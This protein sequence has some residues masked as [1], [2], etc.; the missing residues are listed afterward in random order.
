[1]RQLTAETRIRVKVP[2][3]L[4]RKRELTGETRIRLSQIVD[5]K[6]WRKYVKDEEDWDEAKHPRGQP[7]NSGQ[8]AKVF[9]K[10]LKEN[11]EDLQKTFD[12]A[13]VP[14]EEKEVIQEYTAGLSDKINAYR[15]DKTAPTNPALEEKIELLD[16]ALNRTTLEKNIRTYRTVTARK[17]KLEEILQVPGLGDVDEEDLG[18]FINAYLD[19]QNIKAHDEAFLSTTLDKNY[20]HKKRTSKQKKYLYL[21]KYTI[22]APKEA[23]GLYVESVTEYPGQNEVILFKENDLD[24]FNVKVNSKSKTIYINANLIVKGGTP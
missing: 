10:N 16:R 9:C 4:P 14:E 17:E 19:K 8:F 1:M 23:H 2:L 18:D 20:T 6:D 13:N 12:R 24:I 15:R 7:D 22:D 11:Q 21:L 5:F 3:P